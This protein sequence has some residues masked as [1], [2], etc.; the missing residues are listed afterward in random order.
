MI[1][2]GTNEHG[3]MDNLIVSTY[4]SFKIKEH[5]YFLVK[6]DS[7]SMV[8]LPVTSF[9]FIGP[10]RSGPAGPATSLQSC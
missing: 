3:L 8:R 4:K 6:F 1:I 5:S 9:D 2:T 7:R 10:V